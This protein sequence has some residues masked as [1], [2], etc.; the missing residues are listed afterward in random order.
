ML[1]SK[2]KPRS[3]EANDESK[4]EKKTTPPNFPPVAGTLVIAKFFPAYFADDDSDGEQAVYASLSFVR[5]MAC[6]FYS[7][8]IMDLS[9]NIF[10]FFIVFVFHTQFSHILTLF[11]IRFSLSFKN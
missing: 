2:L 11:S 6:P 7:I 9:A 1:E 5:V 3:N 10:L 4:N 8:I